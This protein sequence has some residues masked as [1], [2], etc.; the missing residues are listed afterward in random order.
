[1]AAGLAAR[2]REQEHRY[3]ESALLSE[4]PSS[5]THHIR[6]RDRV[7]RATVQVAVHQRSQYSTS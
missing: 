2:K 3:G 6:S 4:Q 7:G 5:R 1:M